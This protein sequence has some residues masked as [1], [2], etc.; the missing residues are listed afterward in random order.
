V[1]SDHCLEI[2]VNAGHLRSCA[3]GVSQSCAFQIDLLRPWG[4]RGREERIFSTDLVLQTK[5]E[6][7]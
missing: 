7:D 2:D 6:S 4:P 1:F 3:A 5:E